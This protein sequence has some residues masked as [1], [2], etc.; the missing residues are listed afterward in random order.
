L[1]Y[2]RKGE[3]LVLR[4]EGRSPNDDPA[5]FRIKFGGSFIAI[6]GQKTEDAPTVARTQSINE[7]GIR[8]NSVGT[9]V[10]VVPK[11]KPPKAVAVKEE[12]PVAAAVEPESDKTEPDEKPSAEKETPPT[13]KVVVTSDVATVFSKKPKAVKP[14]APPRTAAKP[15]VKTRKTTAPPKAE[16]I[17]EEPKPDPLASIFLVVELKNGDILERPMS[18][19]ARFSVDKGVLTVVGKDGKTTR[20]SILDVSKVTIQ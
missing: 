18:E 5:E 13:K 15:P 4:V 11:P 6:T 14:K 12:E 19:V 10:E 1:I 2:L 17:P 16:K 20:Y 8:V 9:I 7:S 3:R